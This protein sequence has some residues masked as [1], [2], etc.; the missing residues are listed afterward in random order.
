MTEPTKRCT[1]CGAE[2]PLSAYHVR[3][4]GAGWRDGG[5][6]YEPPES[7]ARAR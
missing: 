2:K 4:D 1:K 7:G 5:C 3:R 6:R